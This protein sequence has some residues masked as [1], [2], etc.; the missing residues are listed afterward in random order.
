MSERFDPRKESER[1]GARGYSYFDGI[2]YRY[3]P[4]A[5]RAKADVELA[6]LKSMRATGILHKR[7]RFGEREVELWYRSDAELR[8]AIAMLEAELN[9]TRPRNVMVRSAP[10]KG[11]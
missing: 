3:P 7:T 1:A 10:N 8:D 11:W 9:P 2:E 6:E 5:R 4:A